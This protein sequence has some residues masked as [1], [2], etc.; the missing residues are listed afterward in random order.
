MCCPGASV[1]REQERER[2]RQSSLRQFDTHN[3]ILGR[4]FNKE[5]ETN[6]V[7][8]G[9]FRGL[10]CTAPNTRSDRVHLG[11]LATLLPNTRSDRVH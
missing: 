6:Q 11:V 1:A 2:Q 7:K 5:L 9:P 8:Q 4:E 10:S 3:I